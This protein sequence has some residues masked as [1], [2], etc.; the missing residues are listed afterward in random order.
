MRWKKN[1]NR[2]VFSGQA[3]NRY[4]AWFEMPLGRYAMAR[5]HELLLRLSPVR[6]NSRILDVGCGTAN[7]LLLFRQKGMTFG[8]GVDVSAE[9]LSLAREKIRHQPDAS[10]FLIQARAEALPFKSGA[11]SKIT[12]VTA[13]EFFQDPLKAVA[14]M[15]R[16]NASE[17]LFAVLNSWSISSQWRRLKS[18]FSRNLFRAAQFYSPFSLKKLCQRAGFTSPN[19]TFHWRTTLHFFPIFVPLFEGIFR[20]ADRA[21]TSVGSPF[22]AFL[23]LHIQKRGDNE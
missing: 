19:W 11:F 8:V 1:E 15:K 18:Y 13:L 20:T 4:D 14:E 22:G 5:E 2:P 7:Q 23:A 12:S 9:M 3:A 17:Y 10:I 16:L 6:R 21:L